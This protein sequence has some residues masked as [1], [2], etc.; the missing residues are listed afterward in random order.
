MTRAHH[1]T[2]TTIRS[3]GLPAPFGIS[4]PIAGG[5]TTAFAGDP[6]RSRP[7]SQFRT[8]APSTAPRTTLSARAA[9]N[10]QARR[11][12]QRRGTQGRVPLPRP[13]R[14]APRG[15][16][17]DGASVGRYGQGARVK[18]KCSFKSKWM[19]SVVICS[20]VARSTALR[21][22]PAER[23]PC[24]MEPPK[25]HERWLE[26]LARATSSTHKSTLS[27]MVCHQ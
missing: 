27:S 13:G 17:P 14:P 21:K 16:E 12:L 1:P 9:A 7:A 6:R 5:M 25:W 26:M 20:C 22:S 18:E 24:T 10:Q 4:K 15:R 2:C 8:V 3:R 23:P 11:E 19:N